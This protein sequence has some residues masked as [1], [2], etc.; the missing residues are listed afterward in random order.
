MSTEINGGL[1]R[2]LDKRD[3]IDAA[4]TSMDA[5]AELLRKRKN[6][7]LRELA[8]GKKREGYAPGGNASKAELVDFLVALWRDILEGQR[9]DLD[10]QI[11]EEC[12]P[13][14]RPV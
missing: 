8:K 3:R 6:A 5:Y 4:L 10:K 11:Q 13:I 2:I 12:R 9:K 14:Y 1:L 7:E